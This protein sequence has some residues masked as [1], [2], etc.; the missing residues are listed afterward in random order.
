MT[1]CPKKISIVS[2]KRVEKFHSRKWES[3]PFRNKWR[4][5]GMIFPY[6]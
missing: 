4:N 6:I 5:S 1:T 2:R 3:K